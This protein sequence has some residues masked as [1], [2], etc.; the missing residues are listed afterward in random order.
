LVR[1]DV[2][3]DVSEV[4][5]FRCCALQYAPEQTLPDA[6]SDYYDPELSEDEKTLLFDYHE[7]VREESEGPGHRLGGHADCV[8]NPMEL[9]CQLVTNGLYCGNASGYEDPRSKIL[10][11][12][13]FDWRLLLQIDT[14]NDACMMW[15]DCG[16]IYYWIREEDLRARNF[17]KSWLILQCS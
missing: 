13:A 2:P 14:D 3:A 9:E 10:A 11:P 4:G 1:T 17:D 15:G 7:A 16:T 6:W 8:Q 12:G 5:R